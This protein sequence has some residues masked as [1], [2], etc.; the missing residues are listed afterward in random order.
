MT[1]SIHDRSGKIRL[2]IISQYIVLILF[3]LSLISICIALVSYFEQVWH[4]TL[5][6]SYI[7]CRYVF[8]FPSCSGRHQR[9]RPFVDPKV[10]I[11]NLE[12]AEQP[13]AFDLTPDEDSDHDEADEAFVDRYLT[14]KSP[15]KGTVKTR[16]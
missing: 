1:A 11:V 15:V 10:Q 8:H 6:L 9:Y 4:A 13:E 5:V 14:T 12:A 7:S 2:Y 3:I 16:T